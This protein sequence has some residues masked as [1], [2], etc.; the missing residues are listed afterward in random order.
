VTP[1]GFVIVYVG[2][3]ATVAALINWRCAHDTGR[4]LRAVDHLIGAGLAVIWPLVLLVLAWL[5]VTDRALAR[6]P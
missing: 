5:A 1:A 2:I 4:P 6:R 3:G